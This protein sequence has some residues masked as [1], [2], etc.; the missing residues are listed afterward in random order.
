MGE[1]TP[2]NY[3]K[4]RCRPRADRPM[5]ETTPRNYLK[6]RCRPRADRPMGET[7]P[8]KLIFY[9]ITNLIALVLYN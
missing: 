6:N 8:R 3:L 7:T 1:T 5:G 4:N 2:R 9:Q